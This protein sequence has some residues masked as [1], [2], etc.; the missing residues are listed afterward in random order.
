MIFRLSEGFC[1]ILLGSFEQYLTFEIYV[2]IE[3]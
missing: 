3:K 1:L 2:S